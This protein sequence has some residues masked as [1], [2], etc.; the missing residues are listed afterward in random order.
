ML[1]QLSMMS[2]NEIREVM[3]RPVVYEVTSEGQEPARRIGLEFLGVGVEV[4]TIAGAVIACGA[5]ALLHIPRQLTSA[6]KRAVEIKP[7]PMPTA[8]IWP[9]RKAEH[10][11]RIGLAAGGCL[12]V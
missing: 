10:E 9:E 8:A 11:A 4:P 12:F 5:R 6:A 7:L 2:V 3:Q 1:L